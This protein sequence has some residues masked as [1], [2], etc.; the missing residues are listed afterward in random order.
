MI[1]RARIKPLEQIPRELICCDFVAR[2]CVEEYESGQ[3]QSL[4]MAT[5]FNGETHCPKCGRVTQDK[6]YAM[7]SIIK[8]WA[9]CLESYDIDE[10]VSA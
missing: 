10:G 5:V 9:I 8:S 3:L 4:D 7:S 2:I 6:K 1:V